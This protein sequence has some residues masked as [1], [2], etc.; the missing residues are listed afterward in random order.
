M[1]GF[2]CLGV[3]PQETNLKL[4]PKLTDNIKLLRLQVFQVQGTELK[5]V[6]ETETGASFKCG[7]FG[8]SGLAERQLATGDFNGFLRV[9]DLENTREPIMKI[10]V[11]KCH[12]LDTRY[13][14]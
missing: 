3:S 6:L 4:Y 8:A 11:R 10:Q 14:I 7:T 5:K 9:F 13:N 2:T 1:F 12:C